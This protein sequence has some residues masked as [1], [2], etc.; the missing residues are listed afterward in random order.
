MVILSV[1]GKVLVVGN[2]LYIFVVINYSNKQN[3]LA[4]SCLFSSLYDKP[5]PANASFGIYQL[6]LSG[7]E[8]LGSLMNVVHRLLL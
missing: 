4:L 6:V 8:F 1:E 2:I 5:S 3:L 7:R